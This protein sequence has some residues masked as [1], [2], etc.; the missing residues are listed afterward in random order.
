MSSG[1]FPLIRSDKDAKF[2]LCMV[3]N[4]KSLRNRYYQYCS[5]LDCSEDALRDG[6]YFSYFDN[7]IDNINKII[8]RKDGSDE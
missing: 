3:D 4:L 5:E 8:A 1:Y 7:A 6:Y 2:L